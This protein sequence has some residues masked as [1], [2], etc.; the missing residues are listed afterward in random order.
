L[1]T[2]NS[3]FNNNIDLPALT[4]LYKNWTELDDDITVYSRAYILFSIL[5]LLSP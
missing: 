5:F 1:F 4:L 3:I 2:F